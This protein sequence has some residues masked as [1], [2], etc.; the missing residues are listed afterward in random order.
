MILNNI[1][2]MSL[3]AFAT[4][5]VSCSGG[6]ETEAEV[7]VAEVVVENRIYGIPAD[8]Y[9]LDSGKIKLGEAVGSIWGR[10]GVTPRESYELERLAKDVFPMTKIRG[11]NSYTTFIKCD[12]L[13]GERLDYFVYDIDHREYVVFSMAADSLSVYR[14]TKEITTRRHC[15][16]AT[17]ESSMWGA[18]MEAG[19]PYAL[20]AEM[21][22]IYQWSV[23]FFSI[24]RGD[25]FT[26]IYDEQFVEDTISIGMGRIWGAKFNHAGEV[27]YAI[28]FEQG[29][30]MQFW[31]ADGGS[32]RKQML[33][34]PLKYSRISS[35]F[36]Y[37]RLH[38][39]HKVYRPHTGVDYA[40]PMGTPVHSV[41]D[42]VVTFKGWAGGGGNTLKVKHAGGFVTGYLHLKSYAKGVYPGAKVK[43]GQ[44]IGYVGVT[45][46]A[47]GPH[48]DYRIWKGGV[49]I[50]PLKVPQKPTEPIAKENIKA[51]DGVKRWVM[52]ELDGDIDREFQLFDMDEFRALSGVDQ[53]KKCFVT[54]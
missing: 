8:D 52:A 7:D 13:G 3:L 24:K 47:T 10:Y 44:T 22:D 31:E 51:F 12:S 38:P 45:G 6:E 35:G 53:D 21:E 30:R 19:L 2:K 49:P 39:I 26:V 48:L 23:D 43:Q 29:G 5:V 41:A 32:L 17:I 42:G 4:I 15:R 33:K 40:A 27:H 36:S 20:G 9:R 37:S 54:L 16:T 14:G 11:G 18:I 25:S 46:D 34:A 28:P 1:F 50:N